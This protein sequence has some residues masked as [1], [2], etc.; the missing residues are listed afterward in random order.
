M[1]QRPT[2]MVSECET[3]SFYS[4]EQLKNLSFPP[5]LMTT[6]ILNLTI[7]TVFFA[8]KQTIGWVVARSLPPFLC[9]IRACLCRQG[10]RGHFLH[11]LITVTSSV[12][13]GASEPLLNL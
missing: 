11:Q 1:S 6:I 13:G 4:I 5:G 2:A 9:V 8:S 12:S 7:S 10:K 3:H